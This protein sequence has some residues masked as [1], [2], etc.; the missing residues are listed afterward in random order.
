MACLSLCSCLDAV[1]RRTGHRS[2]LTGAGNAIGL[3]AGS[4]LILI[5][6]MLVGGGTGST[7]GGV[8]L[9]R[10]LIA[11]SVFR[12]ILMRTCHPTYNLLPSEIKGFDMRWSWNQSWNH[13]T[14]V[15]W[16]QLDPE[17]WEMTNN[18]WVVLQTVS[19][20]R[21]EQVSADPDFCRTLRTDHH[22]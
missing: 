2:I 16:R 6:S 15:V 20:D 21:I 5:F 19:R 1:V 22:I 3:D 9:L 12:L 13:A 14:D 8:K 4:K 7:A 18:P 10:L 11:A 17:L